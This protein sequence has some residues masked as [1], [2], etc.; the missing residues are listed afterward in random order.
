[1]ADETEIRPGGEDHARDA[2]AECAGE[3]SPLQGRAAFLKNWD[4]QLVASL[5]RGSCDR[6]KALFGHNSETHEQVRQEWEAQRRDELTLGKTVDFLR[7]C[8]RSAPFLFFNGNTIGEIARRIMDA[9]FSDFPLGR[10]R[11]AASLAAHYVAG[12]LDREAMADGLIELAKLVNF[13]PGDRVHTLK[14]STRGVI[15][16]LQKDG[17]VVWKPDGS[18]SELI[19]LPESLLREK[20]K[21]N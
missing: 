17:R 13:N 7:E 18:N 6:G 5:N 10:R 15:L 9:V 4:W 21:S 2:H 12:V 3:Q 11:E 1:M 16:R 20:T 14:G 19:A 8:H